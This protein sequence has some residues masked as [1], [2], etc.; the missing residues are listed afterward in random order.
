VSSNVVKQNTA[1]GHQQIKQTQTN[2]HK[3]T[4][5]KQQN[6]A[7]LWRGD[8]ATRSILFVCLLWFDF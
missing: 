7:Q 8:K 3:P 1:F 4:N 6:N 2:K 5:T